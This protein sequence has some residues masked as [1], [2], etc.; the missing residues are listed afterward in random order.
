MS[1]KK[2][3]TKKH[4]VIKTIFQIF[5]YLFEIVFIAGLCTWI[6]AIFYPLNNFI[7]VLERF[8][9]FYGFYQ[10][11]VFAVLNNINDIKA[12]EYLSLHTACEHATL[13]CQSN[14]EASKKTL[15]QAI[16]SKQLSSNTFNDVAVRICYSKLIECIKDN[17]INAIESLKIT[18]SHSYE[19]SNLHWRFSILLR[20]L[21]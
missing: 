19:M 1:E 2:K 8:A 14:D 21:K 20:L 7:D 5:L 15:I 11:I 4:I 18:S 13:A 12:D 16:E 10:I 6:S 17:N 9:L 3:I